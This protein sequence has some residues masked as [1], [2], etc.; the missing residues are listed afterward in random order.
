MGDEP[1]TDGGLDS[2][3][4][5]NLRYEKLI[6][7]HLTFLGTKSPTAYLTTLNSRKILLL[8]TPGFD[9]SGIDNLEVL[10]E[11]VAN[12]YTFALQRG[13]IETRG[14]IFLHDISETRFGGSQRKT[15]EILKALCGPK[16]MRN[17]VIGTT[18]WSASGT[19]KLRNEES[20]E[21]DFLRTH[22]KGIL[23]TTRVAENDRLAAVGIINDIL[24]RPPTLLQVQE[25]MLKPPHTVETT[26]AGK[27]TIPEGRAEAERLRK[28]LEELRI[29]SERDRQRQEARFERESEEINRRFEEERVR[30]E[31]ENERLRR[32][33]Q[34]REDEQR[35]KYQDE[36]RGMD[37]E[38]RRQMRDAENERRAREEERQ[39]EERQKWREFMQEQE[40]KTREMEEKRQRQFDLDC[41]RRD[42]EAAEAR[43][44]EEER[45]K[46][47][48]EEHRKARVEPRRVRWWEK[49]L[50]TIAD[51]AVGLLSSGLTKLFK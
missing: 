51:T 49:A 21:S 1:I 35:R 22:W 40:N 20:R 37:E 46:K 34:K 24:A 44:R 17:C 48:M 27:I 6:T 30:M 38:H 33:Y 15:L 10:N 9:D 36:I 50:G 5:L 8:D 26:T 14:V 47:F 13:E 19:S 31:E 18:M 25:E 12:L 3:E 29:E 42:K 45:M 32:E 4:F 7:D 43:A 28:D 2:C 41:Q 11:I 16:G 23:K 39:Q